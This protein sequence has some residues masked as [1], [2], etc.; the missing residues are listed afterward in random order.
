MKNFPIQRALPSYISEENFENFY[1]FIKIWLNNLDENLDLGT[2]DISGYLT[3]NLNITNDFAKQEKL[4][5]F[6]LG[7]EINI[8][9]GM[10]GFNAFNALILTK[11]KEIFETKGAESSIQFI[12]FYY[13][14]AHAKENPLVPPVPPVPPPPPEI[15]IVT[16]PKNQIM[17]LSNGNWNRELILTISDENF[18]KNEFGENDWVYGEKSGFTA[19][20]KENKIG[21]AHV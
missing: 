5:E 10:D 1:E 18:S 8:R 11:A 9:E 17:K 12:F 7:E 20:I 15:P 19:I 6:L 4:A 16:Y 13:D 3:Q 2:F 14:F 21:R